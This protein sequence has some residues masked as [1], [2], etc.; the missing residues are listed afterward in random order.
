MRPVLNSRQIRLPEA[1]PLTE[2]DWRSEKSCRSYAS[3][4]LEQMRVYWSGLPDIGGDEIPKIQNLAGTGAIAAAFVKDAV[5]VQEEDT[6]YLEVP[7]RDWGKDVDRIGFDPGNPWYRAQMWMLR[8][9]I[10]NWDGSFG[11]VPFVHFDPLDLCNQWRGNDLFMDY[12][13]HPAELHALLE[14]ATSCVLEL[15]SHMRANCLDGYGFEGCA[16]GAWTPGNYLS[17]DAGDMGSPEILAEF[18][19]PYTRRIVQAWGG[20]Y[21]HHHELGIHQ[22]PAWAECDGLTLQFL[23]R[24]PNTQH[25][26]KVVTDEQLKLSFKVAL[27]FIAEYDEFAQ[28]ADRWATGKCVVAVRCDH[29]NQAR[30]ISTS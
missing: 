9:Y 16:M 26:A 14:R 17:C 29:E 30:K 20:A 3:S 23:N 12:Y 5:V 24:D 19:V 25:L 28:D 21:L 18:G 27:G 6:N 13:D 11:I 7:I 8:E 1:V 10:E 15:E 4:K 2:V 22:I